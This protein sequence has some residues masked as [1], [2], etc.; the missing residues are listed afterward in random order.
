MYFVIHEIWRIV[1]KG[2]HYKYLGRY[3]I[4]GPFNSREEAQA[5][6]ESEVGSL[7]LPVD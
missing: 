5:Y 6:I 7:V 4:A 3:D 1:E 2:L